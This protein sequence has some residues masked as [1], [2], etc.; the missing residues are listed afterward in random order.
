[1]PHTWLDTRVGK[2]VTYVTAALIALTVIVQ[3]AYFLNKGMFETVTTAKYRFRIPGI[4]YAINLI[5]FAS[6]IAIGLAFDF[7]KRQRK[8]KHKDRN[9]E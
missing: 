1:M 3:I 8:K 7:R 9:D 4:V 2:V 5:L 6:A